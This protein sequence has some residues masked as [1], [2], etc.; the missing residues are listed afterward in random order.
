MKK[1]AIKWE[2]TFFKVMEIEGF[3]ILVNPMTRNIE[4]D[5]SFVSYSFVCCDLDQSAQD[6]G[7][8]WWLYHDCDNFLVVVKI[9]YAFHVTSIHLRVTVYNVPLWRLCDGG[10]SEK[11]DKVA[12]EEI[13]VYIE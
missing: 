7:T 9:N 13:V 11:Y 1:V 10:V 3:R 5:D 8:D 6:F 4:I 12:K 2:D